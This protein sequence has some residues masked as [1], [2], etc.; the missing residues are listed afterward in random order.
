LCKGHK[1]NSERGA[2]GSDSDGR[3]PFWFPVTGQM[4]CL[5]TGQICM[6]RA[7][8]NPPPTRIMIMHHESSVTL[9][10]AQQNPPLTRIMIM[11]H[12]SSADQCHG[13]RS[14]SSSGCR[15]SQAPRP[16]ASESVSQ[17]RRRD[18]QSLRLTGRLSAVARPG[19]AR[20]RRGHTPPSLSLCPC[21]GDRHRDLRLTGP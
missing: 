20:S 5:W 7:R 13:A 1:K 19:A 18:V 9:R 4:K 21:H 3:V 8:Q 14:T 10:R 12:E 15:R 17:G 16:Q 11:H 6:R 2:T